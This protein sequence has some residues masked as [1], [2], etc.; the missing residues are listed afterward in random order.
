MRQTTDHLRSHHFLCS[1]T[2]FHPTQFSLLSKHKICKDG[3]SL[4]SEEDVSDC[5][6]TKYNLFVVYMLECSRYLRCMKIKVS[7]RIYISG[8]IEIFK[9]LTPLNSSLSHRYPL[10][11]KSRTIWTSSAFI[12][13]P[14]IWTI[15]SDCGSIAPK[16]WISLQISLSL[17]L[18]DSSLRRHPVNAHDFLSTLQGAL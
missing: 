15:Y 3:V 1:S 17:L 9:L 12:Y 2:L 11:P 13:Q 14:Q 16:S 7:Q 8:E 10:F 18:P 4:K 6:V 5:R